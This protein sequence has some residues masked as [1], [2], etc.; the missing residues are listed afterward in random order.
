MARKYTSTINVSPYNVSLAQPLDVRAV[1]EFIDDLKPAS[2]LKTTYIGM[3]VYVLEDSSL[4]VCY[5]KP[6]RATQSLTN[7]EDGWR[8]VDVD[9]SVRIVDNESNL[10][11]GTTIMFP[12]QGM[13]AYVTSEESL[14][15]LLTKGVNNAKDINNWRKISVGSSIS[16]VV[17]KIGI[18]VAPEG[19]TGFKITGN[20]GVVIDDY[21]NAENYIKASYAYT[22]KGV[23]S[24]EPSPYFTYDS[25]KLS[26]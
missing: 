25:V 24:F 14:Y 10:T 6:A 16:P 8:K 5:S 11:D 12:Y 17:D 2:L 4:Y 13:M 19:G 7:V 1:V 22:S 23:N 18:D 21:V 9:Y 26:K 3:V 15:I 20:K